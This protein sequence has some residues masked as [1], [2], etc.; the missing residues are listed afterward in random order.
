MSH[1]RS[2]LGLQSVLNVQA[3][4]I[5]LP[6]PALVA[7]PATATSS[8]TIQVRMNA[9]IL[10]AVRTAGNLAG[11]PRPPRRVTTRHARGGPAS[12][13]CQGDRRRPGDRPGD[14]ID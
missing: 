6:H 10:D 8:I 9:G 14:R 5:S 1:S 11:L 4:P 2:P 7:T 3:S 13:S 12:V